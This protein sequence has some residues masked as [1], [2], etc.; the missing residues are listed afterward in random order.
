MQYMRLIICLLC[1]LFNLAVLDVG[2]MV[3][4][5]FLKCIA[6]SYLYSK[7]LHGDLPILFVINAVTILRH[8]CLDI[9]LPRIRRTGHLLKIG[10]RGLYVMR[11]HEKHLAADFLQLYI[12]GY[13]QYEECKPKVKESLVKSLR[14]LPPDALTHILHLLS[15]ILDKNDNRVKK[16]ILTA[17]LMTVMSKHVDKYGKK[18]DDKATIH[19]STIMTITIMTDRLDGNLLKDHVYPLAKKL[20]NVGNKT[21][22]NC[23]KY[24]YV[25]RIA[26]I[27]GD[28]TIERP[29]GNTDCNKSGFDFKCCAK[30]RGTKYCSAECQK[31]NWPAHKQICG[32]IKNEQR[33]KQDLAT[34]RKYIKENNRKIQNFGVEISAMVVVVDITSSDTKMVAYS[35][36]NFFDTIIDTPPFNVNIEEIRHA[37]QIRNDGDQMFVAI[38]INYDCLFATAFLL[39]DFWYCMPIPLNE[40]MPAWLKPL[41]GNA[42]QGGNKSPGAIVRSR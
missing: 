9:T 15:R 21:V 4:E 6:D 25:E 1:S 33:R 17:E 18:E 41:L 13:E 27:L 26:E 12:S 35:T 3:S 39:S 5:D 10:M 24:R 22:S 19:I 32:K 37:E 16:S 14:L 20:C 29:C 42:L 31:A 30:C 11:D 8:I 40:D 7:T 36:A 28:A 38:C 23:T 34:V 2:Q